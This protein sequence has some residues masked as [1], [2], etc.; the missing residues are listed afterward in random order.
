VRESKKVLCSL[1]GWQ[2]RKELGLQI[3]WSRVQIPTGYNCEGKCLSSCRHV[4][5]RL[6]PEKV[7]EKKMFFREILHRASHKNQGLINTANI[8]ITIS[9][10]LSFVPSGLVHL[11]LPYHQLAPGHSPMLPL[12]DEEA[13]A[14]EEEEEAKEKPR[15]RHSRGKE[16]TL[17]FTIENV[18]C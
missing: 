2:S 18:A 1:R 7:A 12:F 13:E 10:F 3:Q 8:N 17:F 15:G 6:A 14:V 9:F 5:L 16:T 4:N 11:L